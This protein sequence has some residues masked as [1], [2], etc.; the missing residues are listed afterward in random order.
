MSDGVRRRLVRGFGANAFGN[1][2]TIVIQ[3]V[4]VPVLLQSW[5]T[6]IYGE[7]LVLIAVAAFLAMS[8]WG[9]ENTAGN[10]MTSALARSERD[11]AVSI[12]QSVSAMV[13][14]ASA[15]LLVLSS[16]VAMLLPFEK[17]FELRAIPPRALVLIT[18]ALVAHV[19][20]LL[21]GG[22]IRAA[23]RATG[24][25]AV[26]VMLSHIARIADAG[27]VVASALL[28][29]SPLHAALLMLI[30]RILVTLFSW[31]QLS[32]RN[33]WVRFGFRHA[34]LVTMRRMLPGAMSMMAF[35]LGY[36][37]SLHGMV[38]AVGLV[39]GPAAVVAFA[40]FRTLSRLVYQLGGVVSNAVWPEISFAF[41]SKDSTMVRELHRRACQ[42]VVWLVVPAGV[43]LAL[44]GRVLLTV[45]T[46]GSVPYVRPLFYIL[47][48]VA[49]IEAI[50]TASA[51]ALLGVGKHHGIARAYL[52]GA[53]FSVALAIVV[54]PRFGVTGAAAALLV[55][56]IV[57]APYVLEKSLT[58]TGDTLPR[59]LRVVLRP[60]SLPGL[61]RKRP[62]AESV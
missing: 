46:G 53:A 56:A 37:T 35:P 20:V 55:V 52:V 44:S 24:D 58:L 31:R 51:V 54:M 16:A 21:Q 36:A 32:G 9:F 19:A 60:P 6:R 45:W 5:G 13:A 14:L 28:G 30:A 43:A 3:L 4:T 10:E 29:G 26:G 38:A 47:L 2:V 40:T 12:F 59:F 17:W 49:V 48:A 1:V 62:L 18:V 34:T 23:F 11:T 25:Y 42:V 57:F 61:L 50:W 39:L 41:G 15:V 33:P 8:D 7:W 27:V 22:V